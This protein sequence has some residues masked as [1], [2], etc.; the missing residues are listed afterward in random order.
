MTVE[1]VI[2]NKDAVALSADSTVTVTPGQLPDWERPEKTYASVNK[3][4]MLS[5][6]RPVGIMVYGNAELDGVSWETLI[7]LYRAK[8]GNISYDGLEEYSGDFIRF[9]D[10]EAPDMLDWPSLEEQAEQVV[11]SV[12]HLVLDVTELCASALDEEAEGNLEDEIQKKLEDFLEYLREEGSLFNPDSGIE[13]IGPPL[14]DKVVEQIKEMQEKIEGIFQ[15]RLPETILNQILSVCEEL[16]SR[17]FEEDCSFVVIAGYGEAEIFPSLTHHKIWGYHKNA[18]YS[19]KLAAH[20]VSPGTP[21]VILP[22]AQ[23]DTIE[24]FID[25][26]SPE[27]FSHAELAFARVADQTFG[28]FLRQADYPEKEVEKLLEV[29]NEKLRDDF[30]DAM[31]DF[32]SINSAQ[33]YKTIVSMPKGEL[34]AL[35]EAFVDLT[36]LKLRATG[37]LETVGGPADVALISKGDGFVWIKN[38]AQIPLELNP[39]L[40]SSTQTLKT[41]S[42][43]PF[44]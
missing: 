42:T 29:H 1:V 23:S 26:F 15:V 14:R 11:D 9:L 35:A 4:F 31:C 13:K 39:H 3:V 8:R 20:K 18:L 27:V 12:R 40:T 28:N 22:C 6:D 21:S 43:N 24:A 25:D 5:Y 2:M 17:K 37:E 38:K 30:F 33:V 7:K 41:V 44:G 16:L 34:A 36:S 32:A 10:R 19:E